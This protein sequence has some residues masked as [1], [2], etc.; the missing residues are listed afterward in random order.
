MPDLNF[1]IE[2]FS[3]CYKH[4]CIYVKEQPCILVDEKI[5]I[6]G[7]NVFPPP[8]Y[9]PELLKN[10]VNSNMMFGLFDKDIFDL[11]SQS[12]NDK[13]KPLFYPVLGSG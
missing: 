10:S 1:P 6:K 4:M 11:L 7:R 9:L 5:S 2:F 8:S 12:E 13:S 3:N